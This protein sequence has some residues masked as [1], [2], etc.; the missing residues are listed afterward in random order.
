MLTVVCAHR[1]EGAALID[2]FGLTG[3][4]AGRNIY[5][6]DNLRLLLTGQG[7]AHCSATLGRLG[8]TMLPGDDEYWLNF[9]VA[10]CG[11]SVTADW[12][13]SGLPAPGELVGITRIRRD[14]DEWR[15]DTAPLLPP[16]AVPALV[17]RIARLVSVAQPERDFPEPALYDM[18]AGAI[19]RFLHQRGRL[20]RLL[21]VKLVADGPGDDP[22]GAKVIGRHLLDRNRARIVS[23]VT[24]LQ[25]TLNAG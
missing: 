8:D 18:E 24:G 16:V 13:A 9:G 6:R 15:L 4:P 11:A 14:G 10:G 25:Q 20:N 12:P 22:V 2:H 19:A 1:R 17:D 5:T 23:L 3:G 7:G 21:V